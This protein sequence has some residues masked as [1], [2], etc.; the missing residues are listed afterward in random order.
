MTGTIKI[1][2]W[3]PMQRNSL[4]GFVKIEMPSGMILAEVAIMTREHGAWAAPPSKPL[5]LRDG[6][7]TRDTAGKVRYA[8]LI[9]FATKELRDRFS[10][11][12]IGALRVAHPEAFSRS[13]ASLDA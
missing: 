6:T 10:S 2:E 12:V 5:I 4:L 8:P 7:A 3:R 9:S 13:Q 11:A 1:R